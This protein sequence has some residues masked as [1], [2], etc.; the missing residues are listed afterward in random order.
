[1]K[2]VNIHRED[3]SSFLIG[4]Y[5]KQCLVMV[6]IPD[7]WF[8]QKKKA[9]YNWLF[10][11]GQIPRESLWPAANHWQ[12]LSHNVVFTTPSH[13][14]NSYPQLKRF[15][16]NGLIKIE[17]SYDHV[18]PQNFLYAHKLNK[19]CNKMTLGCT[20]PMFECHK[21]KRK[22][23]DQFRKLCLSTDHQQPFRGL[24]SC[25]Q[26]KQVLVIARPNEQY[27][28]KVVI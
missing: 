26:Y 6:A 8:M 1:M 21:W 14:R 25:S 5:F 19:L 13:V 15:S 27:F 9:N 2:R 3:S 12:T 20:R 22:I 18:R 24:L 10:K 7:F 11:E 17:P 16:I 28:D 4:S 23:I